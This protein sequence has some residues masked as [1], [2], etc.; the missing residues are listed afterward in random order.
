MSS[1]F[2][3]LEEFS[4]SKTVSIKFPTTDYDGM[5]Y[6]LIFQCYNI[7]QF[8]YNFKRTA[9]FTIGQ[10]I[11]EANAKL[12]DK[13]I[14]PLSCTDESNKENE[15]C[16]QIKHHSLVELQTEIPTQQHLEGFKEFRNLSPEGQKKYL[17]P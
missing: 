5:L 14:S 6:S 8:E 13:I 12:N 9:P 10:F 7:P 2:I 4:P 17:C 16:I 3:D 15:Q 11:K 1:Y